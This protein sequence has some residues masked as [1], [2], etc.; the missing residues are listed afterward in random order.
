M[1]NAKQIVVDAIHLKKTPRNPVAL[2]SGGVWTFN[3]R[4]YSLQDLLTQPEL[5][6]TIIVETS[7]EA[8]SDIVWA[9]SGYHN[10][11]IRALGGA[12]KFRAKGAPDIQTPLLEKVDDLERL[13]LN[14]LR[15]D[16]EIQTL[17][18]T[19]QRVVA[20]LGNE[21]LI[22]ASQW[23]PFTLAGHLY[24]VEKLM[25]SIYRDQAAVATV[26]EFTTELCVSYLQSFIHTGV[27]IVSIA[28]P[29]A[30]GDL[31]SPRQFAQFVVP[32][33]QKAVGRLKQQGVLVALHIC[34]NITNRLEL[35]PATGVDLL[36]VDYKVDLEQVRL[37][38]GGKL[39]FAGN[40][41]PVAVMQNATAA[42]VTLACQ[43]CLRQVGDTPGYIL[44][45]GCDIPPGVPLANIQAMIAA[46]YQS[47]INR[48]VNH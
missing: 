19:A 7:K 42:E 27:A 15:Q 40:M 28:E 18:Q 33:L 5:A 22:G 32:S 34:G 48:K 4:G 36:S 2:L 43:T 37:Q 39:A 29:S 30:S 44:M 21:R 47:K 8:E 17:L 13:D 41:N 9:G 38:L 20:G 16:A 1:M 14:R 45:P 10:L 35:V 26:L 23:G 25:R 6:A 11:A 12:I 31:I 24:G 3:R 46:A